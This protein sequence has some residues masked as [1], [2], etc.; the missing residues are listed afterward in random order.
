MVDSTEINIEKN[1]LLYIVEPSKN[2]LE[3]FM[4]FRKKHGEYKDIRSPWQF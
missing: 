1:S 4:A 2:N 3:Q